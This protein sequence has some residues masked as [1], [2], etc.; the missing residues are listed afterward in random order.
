MHEVNKALWGE[1]LGG[2]ERRDGCPLDRVKRGQTPE[3]VFPASARREEKHLAAESQRNGFSLK[4]VFQPDK[5]KVSEKGRGKRKS[6]KAKSMGKGGGQEN[7]PAIVG[8]R[9]DKG[10]KREPQEIAKQ[11]PE[12]PGQRFTVSI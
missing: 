11:R 8:T 12:T 6:R 1:G 9:G 3:P 7:D 2:G 4:V 10:G 5:P